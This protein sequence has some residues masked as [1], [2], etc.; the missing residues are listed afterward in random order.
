MLFYFS[1]IIQ[2]IIGFLVVILRFALVFLLRS[3]I[4]GIIEIAVGAPIFV[5]GALGIVSYKDPQSHCKNGF[6]MTF[7]ILACCASSVGIGCFSVGWK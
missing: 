1:A 5:S 3:L 4:G 2:S 7:S 6:H